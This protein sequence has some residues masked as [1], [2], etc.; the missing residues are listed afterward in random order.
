VDFFQ[1]PPS[2]L[3]SELPVRIKLSLLEVLDLRLVFGDRH[4]VGNLRQV[5]VGVGLS[6]D[7][8]MLSVV[9]K[10]VIGCRTA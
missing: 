6:H 8:L 7:V 5:A 3:V 2:L 4:V 9:C 10:Y 1:Q